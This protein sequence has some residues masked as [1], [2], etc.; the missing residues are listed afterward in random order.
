MSALLSLLCAIPES[1]Q[2]G[3]REPSSSGSTCSASRASAADD[4][5]YR[6]PPTCGW[7]RVGPRRRAV[8][9]WLGT[10]APCPAHLRL[11][12]LDPSSW[13]FLCGSVVFIWI[14]GRVPSA[15]SGEYSDW[16][17]GSKR[18][19]NMWHRRCVGA[20]GT[21]APV[22]V[23]AAEEAATHRTGFR[24]SIQAKPTGGRSIRQ[25]PTRKSVR[26]LLSRAPGRR[27]PTAGRRC[28]RTEC[29]QPRSE[30]QAKMVP[31]A[32]H[33]AAPCFEADD[34]AQPAEE[35]GRGERR[36]HDAGDHHA[37]VPVARAASARWTG[38]RRS[39]RRG[40]RRLCGT[41]GRREKPPARMA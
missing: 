16:I 12:M 33:A 37:L 36:E 23:F 20:G 4:A 6:W 35:G 31:A 30:I 26:L 11:M 14:L 15:I 19:A 24:T 41:R 29:C 40:R 34:D 9:D 27:S 10:L 38:C 22:R 39:G 25:A 32:E 28:L 8:R 18:A 13:T 5:L 1:E 3:G 21:A 7:L 17:A 2:H